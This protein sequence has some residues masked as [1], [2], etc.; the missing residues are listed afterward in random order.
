[1]KGSIIA[2]IITVMVLMSNIAIAA[3]KAKPFN[4]VVV[5]IDSSGTFKGYQFEAIDKVKGLLDKMAEQKE[6]RYQVPDEIYIIS[7]DAVPA[8]IWFGKRPQ[9][10]DLTTE[11][12][13]E[14][15]A[16]RSLY[17]HCTDVAKAFNLASHKLNREPMPASKYLFVFSDLIDEPP[18]SRT[19]CEPP[20]KPSLPPVDINWNSLADA[21][22]GVYWAPDD[23]IVAWEN[24]LADQGINI[25]FY[26]DAEAHNIEL[27][28]PPKARFKMS[29]EER[30]EKIENIK[31]IGGGVLGLIR[32]VFKY[33]FIFIGGLTGLSLIN[34][35]KGNLRAILSQLINKICGGKGGK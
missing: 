6:R 28:P 16:K 8:V 4:R 31:E 9:L 24:T 7:L 5:V 22:I 2:I 35:Y 23:Q 3:V 17:Q 32:G 13:S 12:L 27:P 26:N 19:R 18:V 11:R 15:F 34:R 1:M 21:S 30:K 25:K 20:S 10:E 33:A 29:E 14:L